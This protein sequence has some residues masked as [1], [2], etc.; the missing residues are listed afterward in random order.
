MGMMGNTWS[1]GKGASGAAGGVQDNCFVAGLPMT[2]TEESIKEFF[3]PYG[4]V[5]QCKVLPDHPGKPDRAALVR[6]MNEEQA[7]WMVDN[8]NGNVLEGMPGP[9]TVRFAGAPGGKGGIPGGG[10]GAAL[11]LPSNRYSPYSS[12]GATPT[13]LALPEAQAGPSFNATPQAA[14]Q[15]NLASALSQLIP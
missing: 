11:A 10:P 1:G 3:A 5:Q 6:F 12:Y 9:L 8:L 2:A 14:P 13:G 7:R 15:A 4:T